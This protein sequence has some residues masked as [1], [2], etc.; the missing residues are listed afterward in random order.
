VCSRQDKTLPNKCCAVALAE[1]ERRIHSDLLFAAS[2][3]DPASVALS[4]PG[5]DCPVPERGD[6]RA[7][8][9]PGH[10]L[11][12]RTLPS[13]TFQTRPQ[14]KEGI[15]T[16]NSPTHQLPSP[17]HPSLLPA[18]PLSTTETQ[19]SSHP[20]PDAPS[21]ILSDNGF[22]AAAL[23]HSVDQTPTLCPIIQDLE[24]RHAQATPIPVPAASQP[25]LRHREHF[26]R[27]S[28]AGNLQHPRCMHVKL[29]STSE[30]DVLSHPR[31]SKAVAC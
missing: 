27:T 4:V 14:K 26:L 9:R 3:S 8:H 1:P 6:H 31:G 12:V 10:K 22:D 15:T 2:P 29:T 23:A 20:S 28:P 25:R 7:A 16:T 18:L 19:F 24:I 21:I 5:V 11:D 17:V 13:C 30:F